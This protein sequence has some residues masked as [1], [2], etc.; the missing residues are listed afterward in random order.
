MH[1]SGTSLLVKILQELGVFMGVDLEHNSE[2]EFFIEINE[3][4]LQQAGAS[5]DNPLNFEFAPRDFTMT[6]A[7]IVRKRMR[8][9]QRS[10]YLGK[11]NSSKYKSISKLDFSWGWKDP[12]NTF[13]FE[14]WKELFPEAK[15][16]HIH[17]NPTD[18]INSLMKREEEL[19]STFK[20]NSVYQWIK[21]QL[22]A[23]WLPSHRLL[24]HPFRC[25]DAQGT[26]GLWKE[27]VGKALEIT[28]NKNTDS[29]QL[30]YEELLEY[31][32][33]VVPKIAGFCGIE[34]PKN[35]EEISSSLIDISRKYA[36]VNDETLLD[37]YNQ[38]KEDELVR[39][40]GYHNILKDLKIN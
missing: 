36:F 20:G 18:V 1:R 14:V 9:S 27:Y 6:M 10:K 5:W 4:L 28:S 19:A 35:L 38:I 23:K 2:S 7:D 3:W 15:I 34:T 25:V 40:L 13:T 39:K 33:K 11:L 24:Y 16:I 37:L 21:K 17:R 12:R 31:P 30:S 22:F 29:L 32:E 8:S 26:F